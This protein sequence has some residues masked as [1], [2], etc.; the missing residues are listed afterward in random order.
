MLQ[1]LALDSSWNPSLASSTTATSS[2]TTT[3][4]T[5]TSAAGARRGLPGAELGTVS[6]K[7]GS[8]RGGNG[9]I[10]FQQASAAGRS[11]QVVIRR[12]IRIPGSTGC[13]PDERRLTQ[14]SREAEEPRRSA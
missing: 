3:P 13:I 14:S 4:N 1:R 5:A 10:D 7:E 6:G 8:D 2:S 12:M 9:E 11:P